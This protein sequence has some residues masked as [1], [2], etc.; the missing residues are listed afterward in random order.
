M[1][2][3]FSVGSSTPHLGCARPSSYLSLDCVWELATTHVGLAVGLGLAVIL[4][5]RYSKSPWRRVPPGP[6]GLPLLG[7][8]LELQD[9]D[10]LFR[11]DCKQKYSKFS[12]CY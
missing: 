9:K 12:L 7:N 2:G 11:R 5:V 4:V 3:N 8:I 6:R 10:W 1:A